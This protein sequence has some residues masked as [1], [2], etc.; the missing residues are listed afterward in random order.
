MAT[1]PWVVF[2]AANS[3]FV[4]ARCTASGHEPGC[5]VAEITTGSRR[6]A[7]LISAAPEL[8]RAVR[9]A[10][11]TVEAVGTKAALRACHKALRIVDGKEK[12]LSGCIGCE[13]LSLEEARQTDC[14]RCDA[15]S[16]GMPSNRG[17]GP[18]FARLAGRRERLLR[19]ALAQPEPGRPAPVS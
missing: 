16:A 15:V 19:W 4:I 17:P 11:E 9:L 8:E 2:N 3:A 13:I 12:G 18:V 5:V 14:R 7:R 6:H 10:I 1:E